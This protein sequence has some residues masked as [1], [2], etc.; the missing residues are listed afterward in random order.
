[1]SGF[2]FLSATAATLAIFG[3]LTGGCKPRAPEQKSTAQTVVEGFTGKTAVDQ[4]LSAKKQLQAIDL[5]RR[6][7]IEALDK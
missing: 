2:Y 1:M 4:G 7:D 6:Q 5:Q 3:V